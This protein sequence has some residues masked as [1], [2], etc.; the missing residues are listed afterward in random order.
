M[1]IDTD[2]LSATYRRRLVDVPRRQLLISRIAGSEQEPDLSEPP[3]T[4]GLGRVRHFHRHSSDQWVPNP[5]PI[6]PAA[7]YLGLYPDDQVTSQVF[8]NAACNWRCWYCYVPF[9]L[10]AASADRSQWVNPSDLVDAYAQL[11]D[12]PPILDLSGGQPELTPEWALWTIDALEA[13]GLERTVY[14]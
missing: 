2:H 11:P 5:L 8:Q 9:G 3:N 4:N 13:R 12:R 10:L 7:A 1:S 14:L 6:D